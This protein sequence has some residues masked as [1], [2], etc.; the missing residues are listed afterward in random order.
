M[1]KEWLRVLLPVALFAIC[2]GCLGTAHSSSMPGT[3]K[4]AHATNAGIYSSP[5]I[6][7]DGTIYIGSLDGSIYALNAEGTL[8]WSFATGDSI[9]SS[10]AIGRDGTIYIGS[11]DFRLYAINADGTLKWSYMTGDRI[12]SSPA[13][14]PDGTI[15]VGSGDYKLH[16]VNENGIF[17]WSFATGRGIYSSPAIGRDGTIYV[18]S[19]DSKFYA[20]NPDGT[21]KWSFATEGGMIHSSPAIGVDGTVYVG[22]LGGHFCAINPDGSPKW[23]YETGG[24]VSASPAIGADGIIYV[25]SGERRFYFFSPNGISQSSI[26]GASWGFASSP[27][28]AA[29]GT[30]Y[31]GA[32]DGALRA[33]DPVTGK[34]S[35]LYVT[36]DEIVSAPTIG[37]DGTIYVGSLDGSLYAIQTS[38]PGP[39]RTAWPMFRHNSQHTGNLAPPLDLPTLTVTTSGGGFVTSVPTGIEC[40]NACAVRFRRPTR[41]TLL[42]EPTPGHIFSKWSGDCKGKGMC[43]VIMGR[44]RTVEALFEEGACTY[45]ISHKGATLSHMGGTITVGVTAKGSTYCPSPDISWEGD[46][47]GVADIFLKTKGKVA[48]TVP[49]YNGPAARTGSVTIGA[50]RFMVTQKSHPAPR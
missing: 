28:I 16:A 9:D 25:G 12:R 14:G 30:I 41:V 11:G 38:S 24:R 34:D 23:I 20:V 1:S 18:G 13:I 32:S 7:A 26:E 21:L 35:A 6:G 45:R 33:I 4:W 3:L 37:A 50:N 48:I 44:D 8:K 46:W 36:G 49:Q 31:V 40:G 39:A 29:D 2:L 22:S 17:K 43:V 19:S 15:Y 27:A 10:P 42:P 5:A 47:M